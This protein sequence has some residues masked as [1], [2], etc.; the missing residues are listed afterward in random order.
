V[1]LVDHAVVIVGEFEEH[2]IDGQ[3]VAGEDGT[4]MRA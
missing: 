4:G 2:G 3:E 1:R